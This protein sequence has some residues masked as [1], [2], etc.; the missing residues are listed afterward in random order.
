MLIRTR[1]AGGGRSVDHWQSVLPVDVAVAPTSVVVTERRT[2][3]GHL[4]VTTPDPTML[5]VT[6]P[7]PGPYGERAFVRPIS[8]LPPHNRKSTHSTS[9]VRQ[10][11]GR[12][13]DLLQLAFLADHRPPRSFFRSDGSRPSSTSTLSVCFHAPDEELAWIGDHDLRSGAFGTRGAR[14]TVESPRSSPRHI[15][16]DD[17]VPIAATRAPAHGPHSGTLGNGAS[18]HR[19]PRILRRWAQSSETRIGQ[20]TCGCRGERHPPHSP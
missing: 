10:T 5:E 2:S 19:P 13:V 12:V 4:D 18:V 11:S 15:G 3:D 16:P 7:A 17:L 1:P 6:H 8:G 9:W 14:S 20:P